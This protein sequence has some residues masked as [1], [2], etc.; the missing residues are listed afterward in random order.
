[1]IKLKT[2]YIK[3]PDE[4]TLLLINLDDYLDAEVTIDSIDDYES[5]ASVLV[6]DY[7]QIINTDT[8]VDGVTIPADRGLRVNLT[9]GIEDT[10]YKVDI[11]I[12]DDD[13]NKIKI[14]LI[15]LNSNRTL[16]YYGATNYADD[17]FYTNTKYDIWDAADAITK[18]RALITATSAIERLNF[19]G[20][21]TNNN[22]SLQ[23]PR[24]KDTEIP[25]NIEYACY[26][27][28]LLLVD[29]SNVEFE[30]AN[31]SATSQGISSVRRTYDRTS[32]PENVR[33]GILSYTAWAFLKPF[34]RDP[35]EIIISRV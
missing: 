20:T 28:A 7:V 13:D 26:E 5:S 21:K 27:E 32:V 9:G 8:E 30:Q 18:L 3:I 19:C 16:N 4:A 10:E 22:Q 24:D 11:T 31:L 33:A 14:S 25:D 15:A 34:L 17:Y 1:M 23:F 6:V 35:N 29:G 12:I 2:K